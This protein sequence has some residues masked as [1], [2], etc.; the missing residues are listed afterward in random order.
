MKYL[1]VFAV[2][3]L[4]WALWR[5]KHR[6]P[7]PAAPTARAPAVPAPQAMVSCAHCGLHLPRAEALEHA[8]RHY[9]CAEHRSAGPR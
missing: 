9:C 3:A 6:P 1:L 8:R 7:P 4:A 5:N 2:L